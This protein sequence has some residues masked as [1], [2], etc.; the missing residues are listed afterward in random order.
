MEVQIGGLRESLLDFLKRTSS[1]QSVL[2]YILFILMI[3]FKNMIP[4]VIYEQADTFLGRL[5]AIF[6]VAF[7]TNQYGW[8]LGLL[9]ALA[10]ALL[11]G[12]PKGHSF[13]EGFGSGGET[14]LQVIP[15]KKKWYVERALHENPIA[16][17]EEKVVTS[18]VQNDSP[19]GVSGGVQNT[20][21][22]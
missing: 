20:S 17:E 16:I 4:P 11:L 3:V 15:T 22:T 2:L 9:A 19:S 8:I 21:V 1:F 14:A 12:L 6:I 7:L 10:V 18:A 5:L 13:S